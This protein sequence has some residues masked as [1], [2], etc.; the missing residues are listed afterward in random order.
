MGVEYVNLVSHR[1]V[2]E[3]A[4]GVLNEC[5]KR[6]KLMTHRLLVREIDSLEKNT[7]FEIADSA[8]HMDF[9]GNSACQTMLNKI[10]KGK[11]ALYTSMWKVGFITA[12]LI[13]VTE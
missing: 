8:E 9:M 6:D 12:Y 7:L 4:I 13:G 3:L 2:E 5:Y 11:M 10:W 1:E